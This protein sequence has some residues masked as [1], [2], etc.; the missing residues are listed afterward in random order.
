[1]NECL[2]N[3]F[4]NADIYEWKLLSEMKKKTYRKVLFKKTYIIIVFMTWTILQIILNL[5]SLQ[6]N[7]SFE[8]N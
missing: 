5:L 7:F 8:N 3:L 4:V 6:T 2:R 1:M